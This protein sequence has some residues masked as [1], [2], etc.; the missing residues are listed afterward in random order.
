[1]SARDSFERSLSRLNE[2][3]ADPHAQGAMDV[4]RSS[5]AARSN[6]LAAHAAE[7]IGEW[8]LDGCSEELSVAFDRF[9]TDSVRRDPTCA[10][11]IAIAD[12]LNKLEERN[13]DLFR[14]G[15]RHVQPEPVWGG[16]QD[17]AAALRAICAIGLARSDPPDVLLVLAS[18]LADPEP[19]ARIGA[20]RAIA[21]AARPGGG[22]LL[23]YKAHIGDEEPRVI[24]E[25]FVVL[26]ALETEPALDYVGTRLM[27]PNPALAEAAMTA[28][29]NSHL[30]GARALLIDAWQNLIPLGLRRTALRAIAALDD[31]ESFAFLLELLANGSVTD[32]TDALAA[33]VHTS[34]DE[35]RRRRIE[36]VLRQR[37]DLPHSTT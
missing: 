28:L 2:V 19:D 9:L 29:G 30:P 37:D 4:L 33:V 7:I 17:T 22:P 25:T 8:E 31:D 11:K 26:L 1:M 23:W 35:R 14:R 3:R 36:R 12:T 15:V 20:V 10:A 34:G 24:A 6:L 27:D 21:Y 18:L 13:A 5:L 32:A 16:Q